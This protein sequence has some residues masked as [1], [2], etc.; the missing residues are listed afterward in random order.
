M[1][2]QIGAERGNGQVLLASGAGRVPAAR[3][4]IAV[5]K[6]LV[7]AVVTGSVRPGD[8][9]PP[10]SVLIQQFAVSRTV[11][12]ESVKRLEE[13]GLV[14][15]SQGRGTIVNSP[16][17]WNV[18]DPD[19][20]SALVDND[21]SLEILDELAVVRASLE[22]SM[23]AAAAAAQTTESSNDL[24]RMY[25]AGESALRDMDAY[26]DADAA[27][28]DMIMEQ[29]GNRLAA[30]ITRI[31]FARAREST[32]FTGTQDV[33]AVRLTLEEHR[34]IMEAVIAGDGDKAAEEMSTHI[35]RAWSRRRPPAR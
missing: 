3:L 11:I 18:L 16:S 1:S 4:G 26:L 17:R 33:D 9:L 8:A 7:T 15:V 10:E 35:T 2:D 24:L 34:A 30:N 6:D 13:K 5:V 27:F 28:H 22:G 32:R 14:T 19:V 25:E 21:E 12:R 29:S 20:L 31:L 23:A